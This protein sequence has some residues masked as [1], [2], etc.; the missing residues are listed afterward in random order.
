MRSQAQMVGTVCQTD[1][2]AGLSVVSASLPDNPDHTSRE[3][4]GKSTCS[5]GMV[6]RE[7]GHAALECSLTAVCPPVH[8]QLA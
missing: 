5:S 1:K 7:F 6:T 4:A 3:F 2:T 8:L